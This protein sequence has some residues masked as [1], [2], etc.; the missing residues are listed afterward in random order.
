MRVS[1]VTMT[2]RQTTPTAP[3]A[4]TVLVTQTE[5]LLPGARTPCRVLSLPVLHGSFVGGAFS[6]AEPTPI[7]HPATGFTGR[8]E[9]SD[10]CIHPASG[11]LLSVRGTSFVSLYLPPLRQSPLLPTRL[12]PSPPYRYLLRQLLRSL[13]HHRLIRTRLS[14]SSLL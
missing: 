11:C 4:P 6:A 12:L 5:P 13:R 10:G 7:R 9:A 8:L 1:W 3:R 2:S 14:R